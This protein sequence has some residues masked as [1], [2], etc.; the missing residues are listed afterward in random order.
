MEKEAD[1]LGESEEMEDTRR[2][3]TS[4]TT[5]HILNRLAETEAVHTGTT[6]HPLH[7]HIRLKFR[8]F[9]G[10]PNVSLTLGPSLGALLFLLACLAQL[11]WDGFHFILYF[12]LL[13]VAAIS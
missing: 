9:L 6:L 11:H 2:T 7:I 8:T 5:E 12:S 13:C 1:R 4:K 3:R 10:L